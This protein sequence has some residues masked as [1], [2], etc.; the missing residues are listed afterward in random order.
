M[1]RD[2]LY[3]DDDPL[4]AVSADGPLT[5]LISLINECLPEDVYQMRAYIDSILPRQ[6]ADDIDVSREIAEGLRVAKYLAAHAENMDTHMKWGERA[7]VTR[8]LTAAIGQLVRYQREAINIEQFKILESSIMV[9]LRGHPDAASLIETFKRNYEKAAR[10]RDDE[11][12]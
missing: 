8:T 5:Q 12:V 1:K 10:G 11:K 4:D 9:T 2:D 3:S 7:N 6:N